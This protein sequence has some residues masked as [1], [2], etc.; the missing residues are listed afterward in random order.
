[1]KFHIGG[2]VDQIIYIGPSGKEDFPT[3]YTMAGGMTWSST[4]E[5]RE[6]LRKIE[7]L[8]AEDRYSVEELAAAKRL[9][10]DVELQIKEQKATLESL[11]TAVSNKDGLAQIV[12][13]L[14]P[15]FR[16]ER[17]YPRSFEVEMVKEALRG[18]GVDL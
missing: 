12:A 5:W 1:M 18:M 7:A 13:A 3:A 17:Q 15:V 9:L 14:G 10:A 2:R 6:N 8:L 4:G 16:K 11:K